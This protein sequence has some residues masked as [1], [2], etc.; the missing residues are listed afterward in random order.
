MGRKTEEKFLILICGL[1]SVGKT[2]LAEKISKKL[3]QYSLISQNEIRRE[4]GIKKMPKNQE[5]VLRTIDR[6]T[7]SFLLN[8]RGVIFESVNR[9]S[10]RRHQVYGVA[11]GCGCRVIT[12]EIVC[13]EETAKK[14]IVQRPKVDKLLSDPTD[15]A[16]YDRLKALWENIEIDFKYPGEDHVAYIRFDS[17]KKQLQKISFIVS[18][19]ATN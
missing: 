2:T 10:F 4:M 7:A 9:Y 17:E 6:L 13:S 16:V 14:R 19:V 3:K 11:S 12:L 1:P 5:K 8:N 15:P 18:V